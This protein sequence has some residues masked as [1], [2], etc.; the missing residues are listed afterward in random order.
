MTAQPS[1]RER[2]VGAMI[3]LSARRGYP[4]VGIADVCSLA[5]VSN[6][7]FYEQFPSKEECFCAA[8]RSCVERVFGGIRAPVAG[9]GEWPDRVRPALAGLFEAVRKDPDA[10][11]VLFIEALARGPMIRA[12]SEQ[13][14]SALERATERLLQRTPG[15]GETV[16]LPPLAMIGALRHLI[17]HH[18]RNRAEDLLPPLLEDGPTWVQSFARPSA[19]EAWSTSRAA[20]IDVPGEHLVPAT[21]TPARLRAGRHG[22]AAS[23]VARSQRARLI[24]ATAEL[25]LTE[26]YENTRVVDIVARAR[27]AKPTFYRYF[28]DRKDVLLEA[29]QTAICCILERCEEAYFSVEPWPERV[30]RCLETLIA[31]I[32]R[33][34]AMAHA[35]L[36]ACYA[37][38]GAAIREGE[39]LSRPFARFLQEGYGWRP[40]ARTLPP[41]CARASAGAI[42]EIVRR[43]VADHEVARLARRLPQFTYIAIAPFAGAE[44][45]IALVEELK[46][47]EPRRLAARP[48]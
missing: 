13:A 5:G 26:G 44:E 3:D 15:E 27:V 18:L 48:C 22:L 45:A 47:R 37:A 42:F 16:D 25:V 11:R 8:H 9:D 43:C 21:W 30:W 38:G 35:S 12:E 39:G 14:R 20:V 32:A 41:L 23:A 34:P 7:T 40:Q 31:M 2:V 17:S 19:R 36:V 29:Q 10:A 6:A 46:G 1:Q 4:R 24:Q 28:T 33:N